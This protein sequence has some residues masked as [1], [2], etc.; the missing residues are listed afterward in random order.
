M[1]E[2][3]FLVP[4]RNAYG[5]DSFGEAVEKARVNSKLQECR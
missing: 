4:A 1:I 2:R 5:I 3:R